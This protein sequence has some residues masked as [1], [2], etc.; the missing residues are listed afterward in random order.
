MKY[1]LA[2][3]MMAALHLFGAAPEASAQDTPGAFIDV[4]NDGSW[5]AGDLPL[6]D[7]L[8]PDSTGFNAFA[9]QPGWKP[10]SRPVGLVVSAPLVLRNGFV[11]QFILSGDI[12]ILANIKVLKS[13]TFVSF[14]TVGGDITIGPRVKVAGKGD[15]DFQTFD[16]GDI[17]L[18]ASSAYSTRGEF[19]TVGFDADGTLD[20]GE[21][22]GF[23]LSGAGYNTAVLHARDAMT[24][25]P[26]LKTRIAS[27]GY[28]DLLCACD[29]TLPE[30]ALKAG[31]IRIEGYASDRHPAA[32]RVHIVD[33]VL[34][35]GYNNGDFRIIAAA[36]RNTG[37]YAPEALVLERTQ[38]RTR[39]I[40]PL[41]LPEP[42]IR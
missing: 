12:R 23:R 31:Y 29:L 6:S 4:D 26:G 27:H 5:T 16:G 11:Q 10:V 19:N 13:D 33:S 1:A 39:S 35:Q 32:K 14:T 8:G 40:Q 22:I 7:F 18:G 9:A 24:I 15:V 38:I 3:A 21:N 34:N 28:F 20:V 41:Y 42:I 17:T 37:R 2:L 36:D 25:A 30:A